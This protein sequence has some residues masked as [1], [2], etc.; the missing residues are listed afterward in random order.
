MF[1]ISLICPTPYFTD[2]KKT[3]LQMATWTPAFKFPLKIPKLA[4]IKFGTKNKTSMVSI[5]NSTNIEFGMTIIFTANDIVVNPSLFNVNTREEM[6]VEKTM[7]PGDK[8]MIHTYR[9]NKNIIYIPAN[10]KEEENSNHLMVYG[11]KF[12]QIHHGENTYRY[13]A[14]QNVDSLE[15]KIEYLTEYEAM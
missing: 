10:T 8:I 2:I 12:L 14:D 1:Q 4:G 5:I 7:Q 13:N 3:T 15:A 9:Q 11:S 6:K